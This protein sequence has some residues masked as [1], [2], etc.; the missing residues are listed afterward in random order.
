M[1]VPFLSQRFCSSVRILA[2]FPCEMFGKEWFVLQGLGVSIINEFCGS[3]GFTK[4]RFVRSR[5]LNNFWE[6]FHFHWVINL[7]ITKEGIHLVDHILPF[8]KFV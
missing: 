8:S 2:V 6:K 7:K 4:G 3:K 1:I 5:R